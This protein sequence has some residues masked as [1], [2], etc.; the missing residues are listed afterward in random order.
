[1]LF[2][3]D[4]FRADPRYREMLTRDPLFYGRL[5]TW[6]QANGAVRDHK[7]VFIAHLLVSDLPEHREAGFVLLQDLPPYV[8]AA[9]NTAN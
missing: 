2:G 5:A 7:E 8:T 9:G 3:S 6:Y 4:G 1:M